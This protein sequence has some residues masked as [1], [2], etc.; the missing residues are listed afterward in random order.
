MNKTGHAL[1]TLAVVLGLAACGSNGGKDASS[2]EAATATVAAA[3][4]S[5][6]ASI[7]ETTSAEGTA[8]RVDCVAVKS[9]EAS[10]I[11]DWQLVVGFS[12]SPDVATWSKVPIGD[13]PKFASQLEVL[14][15]QLGSDS[16]AVEAINFMAGANEIAQKG[17]G[18]DVTAADELK[19]YLGTDVT[20]VLLKQSA[21]GLAA[22]GIGCG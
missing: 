4:G 9:A 21:I 14:K 20:K 19:Q 22:S 15:T 16:A 10:M 17:I 8:A 3:A 5:S 11:V 18:G 12:R 7:T 1:A 13:L 6:D 2:I